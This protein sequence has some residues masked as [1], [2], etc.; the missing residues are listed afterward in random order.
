MV[1]LRSLGSGLSRKSGE[2]NRLLEFRT[3]CGSV[4]S[5]SAGRHSKQKAPVAIRSFLGNLSH[6]FCGGKVS[7]AISTA[8]GPFGSTGD[9]PE[10]GALTK[11]R[12]SMRALHVMTVPGCSVVITIA[13]VTAII[14]PDIPRTRVVTRAGSIAVS[15]SAMRRVTIGGTRISAANHCSAK[16]A[17]RHTGCERCISPFG[18]LSWRSACERQRADKRACRE[19]T[20]ADVHWLRSLPACAFRLMRDAQ[21]TSAGIGGFHRFAP[22]SVCE[23]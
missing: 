11:R 18:G 7:L 9:F 1:R 8:R 16:S 14:R 20:A 15:G 6:P 5:G 22:A 3:A 17:S 19:N 23:G 13:M 10:P 4:F 2:P 21:R 12:A